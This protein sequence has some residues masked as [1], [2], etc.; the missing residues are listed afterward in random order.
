M[1]QNPCLSKSHTNSDSRITPVSGYFLSGTST[2]NKG[3]VGYMA[4][5]LCGSKI[6]P[7]YFQ[8]LM[9]RASIYY[10]L[11]RAFFGVIE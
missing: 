6:Y 2:G 5:D 4:K 7:P 9:L 1:V 11:V 3:S 10:H 8:A